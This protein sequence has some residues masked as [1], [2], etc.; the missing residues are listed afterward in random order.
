MNMEIQFSNSS[1]YTLIEV[2]IVVVILSLLATVA[3]P[4]YQEHMQRTRRA[5]GKA[6]LLEVMQAQERYFTEN[7]KYTT[8]LMDL[9]Y[10][11]DTVE[12]H[13][14]FYLVSA[15]RCD[16]TPPM[17]NDINECV[18]L[19]AKPVGAQSTDGSLFIDSYGNQLPPDKWSR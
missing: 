18:K 12:S 19:E 15:M 10:N 1:G 16:V 13:E 7:I 2:L 4:S 14:Q 5:D 11:A 3:V 9:D 8:K 17:S 6:I